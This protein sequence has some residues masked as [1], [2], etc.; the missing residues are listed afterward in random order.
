M[1]TH[2]VKKIRYKFN[3]LY[4]RHLIR[5]IADKKTYDLKNN[6]YI[7]ADPRGGSTW[8]ME[9]IQNI[10]NEPV[11]WEPLDLKLKNNPFNSI[12]FDW[13]QH[14]PS[15]ESWPEAKMLFSLLFQGKILEKNIL[16]YSTLKQLNNSN[17]LLFKICRGNALLP[18]LTENFE[19]NFKPIYMVRHPFAVASSQ[20][21][22]GAWNHLNKKFEILDTPF[23]THYKKHQAFLKNI[24]TNEEI[25]VAKWCLSNLKTLN[26][27][28]NNK[29]W[30]SITYE[31]F[32]LDPNQQIERVLKSWNLKYDLSSIDFEN[33]SQTTH[34]DSPSL[35]TDKIKSWQSKFDDDQIERMGEV[36]KY[37][38]TEIYTKDSPM[39]NYSFK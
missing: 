23:N 38:E 7:F 12:N 3:S 26:H 8:L 4:K 35:N 2:L 13:R 17:S 18:W 19:F 24:R 36:L 32:V 34:K 6:H 37:F 22:H 21:R 25:L 33:D 5:P 1:K 20:L 11:I 10:T 39:P 28:N 15:D 9:I 14:I 27:P 16:D 31:D 30:I 29:K